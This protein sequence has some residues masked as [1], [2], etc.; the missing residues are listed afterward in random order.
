MWPKLPSGLEL[1]SFLHRSPIT[2]PHPSWVQRTKLL[3]IYQFSGDFSSLFFPLNITVF[4]MTPMF[5]SL[6]WVIVTSSKPLIVINSLWALYSFC[7]F[8]K[9]K[10]FFKDPSISLRLWEYGFYESQSNG[11]FGRG[12]VPPSVLCPA[13]Q[14]VWMQPFGGT[15]WRTHVWVLSQHHEACRAGSYPSIM[16]PAGHL[17]VECWLLISV[18]PEKR[19]WVFLCQ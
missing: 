10:Q 9:K 16:R 7:V 8:W 19:N 3:A 14:E 13:V 6:G 2:T 11:I 18:K 4:W 17:G 5:P 12:I 1:P 15:T